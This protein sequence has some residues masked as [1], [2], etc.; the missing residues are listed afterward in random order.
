M[1]KRII[2]ILPL[3]VLLVT[4]FIPAVQG[5]TG[6]QATVLTNPSG[7]Q[8]TVDGATYFGPMSAFWPVGS[9]H[10]LSV[11]QATGYSFSVTGDT[12]WQFQ[13]WSWG[14]NSSPN[15]TV[16]VYAN[17][18]I[19]K[20]TAN[21][22]VQYLLTVQVACN[23]G[24]CPANQLGWVSV[25]N[26][27]PNTVQPG[28]PWTSWMSGGSTALLGAPGSSTWIFQGWQIGNNPLITNTGPQYTV[29]VNSPTVATAVFIPAKNVTFLTNPPNLTFYVDGGLTSYNVYTDAPETVEMADGSSHSVT[30]LSLTNDSN[31]KRWVFGS[32]SDGGAQTHTYVV[33]SGFNPETLTCNYAAAAYPTFVTLPAAL[34]LVVDNL[35]LPPPYSYI[36]GV[37]ST[38]T[39]TATSPQ[40]DAQGVAWVFQSW[41]D[42]VTA[43]SRTLTI[44][45]GADVN[46]FR[47]TAV[48]TKQAQLTV[49]SSIAGQAV[50][51]DGS[52]CT[53]PCTVTR[54]PGAQ[55]H[56]SAP[57][58]VPVSANSRQ[59]LLGWSTGGSAPVAGDWVGTLN[60]ASTSIMASYH[61]MNSLTVAATP[62]KGATWRVTPSSAD[63]F[64]DAQTKVAIH[65]VPRPGYRFSNWGGDLSGSDPNAS[66]SMNV[67]HSITATLIGAPTVSRRGIVNGA[68]TGTAVGVAPGSVASLYGEGLS[69]ESAVAP[70]NSLATTLAGVTIRIGDRTVPLYFASPSQINF[71]IPPD[72]PLGDHTVTLSSPGTSDSTSSLSVERNAPGLFSAVLD[73]QLYAMTMHEDGTPVTT[74]A[75]ARQGELLTVYGTGFGPTDRARPEGVAIPASPRYMILDPVTVQVG[76]TSFTPEASFAAP[77]QVGVDLVQFRLD[78]NAPSGAAIP[79]T[80]TVNGVKSNTL[81]LPIE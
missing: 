79:V 57:A 54:N 72:L 65:L 77:G 48:Y 19:D 73:G 36:W 11:P 47:L 23:P 53:T 70:E 44:P 26:Q 56:V 18:S 76:S 50:T 61:L 41:D 62:S 16:Q 9:E 81:P 52:S 30:G 42:G 68:G 8:F 6:T 5:Q 4:A 60:T 20:Y 80:L 17:A 21:F 67:P 28:Q 58:S 27:I 45:V 31:G 15:P 22:A 32:W 34:D 14:G 10:V 55:V 35:V 51:V 64:Y 25:N 29:T 13:N 40:T 38:H 66:L 39:V 7:P 3:P 46:G 33:G 2:S 78:S 12:Q 59:S 71:Q 63:G 1:K 74:A 24:P 49:N 69:A 37:G 75:P 43:P